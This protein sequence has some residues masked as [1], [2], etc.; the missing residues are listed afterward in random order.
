MCYLRRMSSQMFALGLGT[1]ACLAIS[2][3]ADA[4]E[5]FEA[6]LVG[7][8]VRLQHRVDAGLLFDY[9]L[10]AGGS[11]SEFRSATESSRELLA[12]SFAGEV[13]DRVIQLVIWD[14]DLYAPSTSTDVKDRWNV[15][16]AGTLDNQLGAVVSVEISADARR[17]DIFSVSD[18]QWHTHLRD[19]LGGDFRGRISLFTR[20]DLEDNGILT[21]R[22][23]A[24]LGGKQRRET[25][26]GAFEPVL[27]QRVLLQN[28]IP[29]RAGAFG[30][31]EF[32]GVA[33]SLDANGSPN[34]LYRHNFNVP[35]THWPVQD[36]QGYVVLFDSLSPATNTFAAVIYGREPVDSPYRIS[37]WRFRM[38]DFVF[39]DYGVLA[40]LPELMMREPGNG[41]YFDHTIKTFAGLKLD[42]S[43]ADT[44]KALVPLIP[45]PRVY[46]ANHNFTGAL[47]NI[48]DQL[49]ANASLPLTSAMRVD[50]LGSRV[51]P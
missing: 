45:Q 31:E 2:W 4:A 42:Q 32:D 5:E 48:T 38:K 19:G 15:N 36:T 39:P 23:I 12:P 44:I 14:T 9:R 37:A 7:L 34:W 47:K 33:M 24:R 21:V 20:Y 40:V 27:S 43:A 25:T 16:Q 1:L 26:G 6:N 10:G 8:D 13:T 17:V 51:V 46:R 35:L 41:I 28:W 49:R 50:H 3:E 22:R 29:F 30:G 11:I 18:L